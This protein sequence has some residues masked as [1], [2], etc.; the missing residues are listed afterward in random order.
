MNLED[1]F[2]DLIEEANAKQINRFCFYFQDKLYLTF[3]NHH[4]W[5]EPVEVQILTHVL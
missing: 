3:F 5:I 4:R 1:V 2:N